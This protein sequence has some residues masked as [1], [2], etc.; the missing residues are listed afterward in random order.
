MSDVATRETF[1]TT[2]SGETVERVTISNGGLTAKVITWGAVIQDLRL[3]GHQP[4]LVLGFDNYD[5]YPKHSSYFGATPGRNSNRI[6][7]GK[8]SIDGTEYQLELNERGINHLHGGSD[9]IAKRNWTIVSH[10]ASDVVLSITD[11][12]GRAGYP[13]NCEITAT[14]RLSANGTLSVIYDAT[15]DQPTIANLCQHS[16]FNLDGSETILDHEIQILADHYL[17]VTTDLIPTGEVRPVEGSEFNLRELAPIR[18]QIDGN[19][20]NYDHNFCL[21]N[22]R[23]FKTKVAT[24]RSPKSSIQM[25][26]FTTEPG[27]QFYSAS[28]LNVPVPGHDGRVISAY[29]GLCLETQIWPDAVNHENFPEA[30]LHPGETLR[31]ETDYVFS[32]KP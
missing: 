16:Y 26:V 18:R 11:P 24:L 17:P 22:E 15:S 14:Y 1:G 23:R 20:V 10:S 29:A 2:P 9:G 6:D 28:K 32:R 27:V 7:G 25:D 21:S 13:G 3:D 12:D 4:S 31:Q 5:F 30:V 19:V 8:F